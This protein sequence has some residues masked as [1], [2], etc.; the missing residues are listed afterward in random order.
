MP[1]FSQL[2]PSPFGILGLSLGLST[3]GPESRDCVGKHPW[4]PPQTQISILGMWGLFQDESDW[5]DSWDGSRRSAQ[6]LCLVFGWHSFPLCDCFIVFH[7]LKRRL[8]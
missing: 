5:E 4:H 6:V 3:A 7:P 2:T 1:A 8:F